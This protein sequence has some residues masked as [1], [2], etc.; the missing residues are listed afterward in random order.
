MQMAGKLSHEQNLKQLTM[1]GTIDMATPNFL[2]GL[3]K[4]C[5]TVGLI[6]LTVSDRYVS[7]IAIRGSSMSPTFNPHEKKSAAFFMD[8]YALVEKF[9]LEKYKFS[10]GDVVVFR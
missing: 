4:K 1:R 2:F 10:S 5:F 9:C 6:S 3:A 8:D 7:L